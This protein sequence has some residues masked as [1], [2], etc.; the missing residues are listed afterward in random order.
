MQNIRVALHLS[1]G[2]D[3]GSDVVELLSKED[4]EELFVASE[5][6]ET[7]KVSAEQTKAFVNTLFIPKTGG[8][9]GQ[10]EFR[11]CSRRAPGETWLGTYNHVAKITSTVDNTTANSYV[12]TGCRMYLDKLDWNWR[13]QAF[14]GKW[15][16]RSVRL[17]GYDAAAR[18]LIQLAWK[19]AIDHRH[20]DECPFK[21]FL[22]E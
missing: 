22:S 21:D 15:Y 3:R 10:R 19:I 8:G 2:P 18:L 5:L 17:Y 6:N 16:G 20:E 13:M 12:P 4:Q 14:N 7:E 9:K 1:G 11:R